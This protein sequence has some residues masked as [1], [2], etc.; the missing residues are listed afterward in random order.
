MS[1]RNHK[2][3]HNFISDRQEK[4]R[5]GIIL[6]FRNSIYLVGSRWM[7]YAMRL[8]YIAALAHFLGPERYGIYSY[9]IAWYLSFLPVANLGLGVILS[10]EISNRSGNGKDIV[11]Q[12]FGLQICIA[13]LAF[14]I[15]NISAHV[16]E[17]D[18]AIKVVILV[19]SLSLIGRPFAWWVEQV[20][21]AYEANKYSFLL[22]SIFRP[23]EVVCGVFILLF[24]FGILG[25][26]GLHSAWW[27]AQG[28]FGIV[29]I[30]RFVGKFKIIFNWKAVKKLVVQG[31]P[32]GL[33]FLF[34]N[35][36]LQGPIVLFR[37][38][39][40]AGFEL[41]QFALVMQAF[42]LL[43][44]IP[45]AV[46][47]A[48]LPGLSRSVTRR[49]GKEQDFLENIMRSALIIGTIIGFSFMIMGPWIVELTFGSK[50]S[51]AGK[52]LG[53]GLWLLVLW[54]W[55]AALWR[56]LLARGRFFESAIAALSG[57]IVLTASFGTFLDKL[58]IYG[59][60][61]AS[62]MGMLVWIVLLIIFVKT[63][64]GLI[65]RTSI[66]RAFVALCLS[67]VVFL[68]LRKY[69]TNLASISAACAMIIGT[70][71]FRAVSTKELKLAV[72][73]MTGRM[74]MKE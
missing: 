4:P 41:G 61:A 39:G 59:A 23:G 9:G 17:E 28:A 36:F 72:S 69:D 60:I 18:V 20:Y 26:A 58:G 57:S 44:S 65:I 56:V 16:V 35:W 64:G 70:I 24:G 22:D 54:S 37:H 38:F 13:L 43:S 49:N 21:T 2:I 5:D 19:F 8:V 27:W 67:C 1:V 12:T 32:I 33:S 71:I 7:T 34:V 15:C 47:T 30:L 51:M 63:S 55:G 3:E 6:L 48:A 62:A 66:I 74:R 31:I 10:R 29:M 40:S 50:Y 73:L 42:I 53:S 52:F 14:A 68:I 25:V 46:C 45:T 11:S